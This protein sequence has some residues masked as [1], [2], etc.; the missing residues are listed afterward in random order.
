MKRMEEREREKKKKKGGGRTHLCDFQGVMVTQQHKVKMRHFC[1]RQGCET[2]LR[3]L[4]LRL[5]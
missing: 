2:L 4:S 3:T 5:A 1:A